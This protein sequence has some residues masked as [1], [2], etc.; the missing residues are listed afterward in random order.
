[1][2]IA[3]LL[4]RLLFPPRTNL[5]KEELGRIRQRWQKIEDRIS[6]GGESNF[7][8]SVIDADKLFG[9]ILKSLGYDEETWAKSMAKAGDRFSKPTKDGIW[10]AHKLRNRLVHDEHEL[11]SYEAKRSIKKIKRGLKELNI[12]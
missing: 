10:Q 6:E 3:D 1:M 9:K 5:S 11:H 2:G 4:K 8:V 12:L 7:K